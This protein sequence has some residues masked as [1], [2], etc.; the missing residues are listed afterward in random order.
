MIWHV[1]VGYISSNNS[2]NHFGRGGGGGRSPGGRAPLYS[3]G[4]HTPRAPNPARGF[5]RGGGQARGGV[6][7][8]RMRQPGGGLCPNPAQQQ[9]DFSNNRITFM[10]TCHPKLP[11]TLHHIMMNLLAMTSPPANTPNLWIPIT[12]IIIIRKTYTTLTTI[13][14]TL[15]SIFLHNTTLPMMIPIILTLTAMTTDPSAPRL[16]PYMTVLPTPKTSTL[17]ILTLSP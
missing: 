10:L 12:H 8:R 15:T 9:L 14:P 13:K 4:F 2:P 16:S 7:G 6:G 5:P 1:C 3:P 17:H 11:H